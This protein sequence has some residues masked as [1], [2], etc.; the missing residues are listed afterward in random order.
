MASLLDLY[1]EFSSDENGEK[2]ITNSLL[3]SKIVLDIPFMILSIYLLLNIK[4]N[5][6]IYLFIFLNYGGMLE[7]YY[8]SN[9]PSLLVDKNTKKI[10][11]SYV[12]LTIDA[13]SLLIGGY[14]FYNLFGSQ[15]K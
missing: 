7:D 3:T 10:L 6:L 5:P 14:V 12:P 8:V 1:E 15:S 4:F 2:K 9:H 11:T 13:L